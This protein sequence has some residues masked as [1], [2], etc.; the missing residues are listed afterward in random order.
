VSTTAALARGGRAE[1]WAG[2]AFVAP[3]LLLIAVFFLFPVLAGFLL[4]LTDF[5]L[6][7]VADLSAVRVVGAANYASLLRSSVFWRA[8]ANTLVFVVVGGPLTVGAALGTAVLVSAR[9]TKLR[10]LFRTLLFAPVVAT[11][12]AVAVVWRYLY[13][14]RFGF[15]NELL[16]LVG[17][18]PVNWLGEPKTAML[19]IILLAVWKNFGFSMVIFVAALQAIPEHLYEAARI[20]G[21]NAWQ[22][23]RRIT[24]P[25]L[26]PTFLFVGVTTAIG[27][28][29]LF[30]EPYVLTSGTG[31]PLDATLSVVLHM[32]KEG[33]RWWNIGYA[34]SVAFVLFAVILVFTMLQLRLRPRGE[35]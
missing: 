6:Y 26:G 22:Q 25:L 24:V 31:G 11:L 12:V 5:D 34:A 30:S 21:A 20:D 15:L 35:R 32:Y 7:G 2:R 27:Y 1:A 3:A 4:S 23:F 10:G 9:A 29:Q 13:H 33:F 8:F 28:F 16:G 17:I 14:P 19:A 18:E